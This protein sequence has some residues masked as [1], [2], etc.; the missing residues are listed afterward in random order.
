MLFLLALACA[1]PVPVTLGWPTQGCGPAADPAWDQARV[2]RD[3]L[4]LYDPETGLTTAVTVAR[5]AE[6]GCYPGLLLVPPGFEAG[7]PELRETY[8][9]TLAGAGL[10]VVGFDPPGRGKS[11]GVDDHNGPQGQRALAI[12][13]SW[14]AAQPEVDPERVVVRSRSYGVAMAAGAL[15]RFP[16]LTPHALVDIEGPARLPDDLDHAAQQNRDTFAALSQ[17]EQWYLDRS[18][19]EHIGEFTGYYLRI[20]AI[21]DHALGD[22]MGAALQMM[23]SAERGAVANATLNGIQQ[24]EWAYEDV[25]AHALEGRVKYD[26]ARAMELLLGSF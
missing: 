20:Q 11:D 19:A 14:L 21:Q 23:R 10:V 6:E 18:A 16:E 26:D 1:E 22:W 2:R 5:P 15:A 8:A 9:G 17:G 25:Q 13:L 3:Q 7:Q 24:D 4:D 12:V